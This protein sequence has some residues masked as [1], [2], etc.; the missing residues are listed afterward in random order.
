MGM[1]YRKLTLSDAAELQ[2]LL[3]SN[4]GYTRRV[5]GR[6]PQRRDSQA[7]LGALPPDINEDAKHAWGLWEGE[8]LVA[9][10]DVIRGYPGPE[11]AYIGLLVTSGDQS[12]SG[13]GKTVYEYVLGEIR[14]WHGISVVRLGV[15]ASNAE[16]AEPFWQSLGFARTGESKPYVDGT[17][18]STVTIWEYSIPIPNPV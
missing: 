12:R 7:I 11:V 5:S 10:V 16:A 18:T 15:V 14:R 3:E 6:D 2:G 9:F 8:R 1:E 4:P 13:L 17:V